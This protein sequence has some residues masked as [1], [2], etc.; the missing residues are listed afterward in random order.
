MKDVVIKGGQYAAEDFEGLMQDV[1]EGDRIVFTEPCFF[2]GVFTFPTNIT[3]C[4]MLNGC[5]TIEKE[6]HLTFLG[7][8]EAGNTC[9]FQGEGK[10]TVAS[11]I[12]GNPFWFGA[13]GDGITDD[14]EAFERTWKTFTQITLPYTEGGYLITHLKTFPNMVL[15]GQADRHPII[16]ASKDCLRMF[17]VVEGKFSVNHICFEMLQA[18]AESTVFFFDTS[19]QMVRDVY[20]THCEFYDAYHVFTDAQDKHVMMFMHFEDILCKDS[21]HSTF[22]I[23]DFEGFIFLKRFVVD[24]ADSFK[25]HHLTEGF[26][27]IDIDDVRGTIFEEMTV[28]GSNSGDPK[29]IGFLIP[30]KVALMASLWWD[31]VTVR[32]MGGYGMVFGNTVIC[33]LVHTQIL[34][35]GG[36]IYMDRSWEL[37]IEDILIDGQG[38][39]SQ[40]MAGIWMEDTRFNHLLNVVCRNQS[41][42][43]IVLQ[44][45]SSTTLSGCLIE[46]NQGRGFT[47]INGKGNLCIQCTV[48]N[49]QGDKE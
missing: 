18:P 35:C 27:A 30:G 22:D 21:R 43:G 3:V 37:Q 49:N 13:K 23:E 10:V 29:E 1:E 12:E 16:R 40:N 33:S 44:N 41:G 20:I 31:R 7:I 24:N 4:F 38:C 17:H 9:L 32:D 28:I 8:I 39:Y 15:K 14:T 46:N 6:A 11:A 45:V 48:R 5:I 42:D 34:H 2:S 47:D 25:K 19:V 26:A 36:G